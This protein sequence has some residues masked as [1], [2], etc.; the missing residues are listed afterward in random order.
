MIYIIRGFLY[1][2]VIYCA[3]KNGSNA[4]ILLNIVLIQYSHYHINMCYFVI[5]VGLK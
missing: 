4:N 2:F 3:L 5:L 1:L